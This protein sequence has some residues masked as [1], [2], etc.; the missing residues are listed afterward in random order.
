MTITFPDARDALDAAIRNGNAAAIVTLGALVDKLDDRP[1]P[2][3]LPSALWY[4]A[5]G[6]HVFPLTP[7]SKIPRPRSRGC[8]DATTDP[9]TIRR[10]WADNPAA[11]VGIATGHV[12][13][14]IDVDGPA[15]VDSW[16]DCGNL[17]PILGIVKTPREGGLHLYVATQPERGNRAN[18]IPGIDYRGAGGYVVAPPSR[19]DVGEYV[20]T[21]PLEVPA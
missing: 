21:R 3:L 11:N 6:L 16:L 7:Q 13:D 14:V 15:G 4:A 20:W 2:E 8:H 17:P 9:G 18:L 1:R 12:V 10:W 19:T 5:Q